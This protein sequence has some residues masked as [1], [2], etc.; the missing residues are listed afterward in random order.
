[1]IYSGYNWLSHQKNKTKNIHNDET[2]ILNYI[3]GDSIS[4]NLSNEPFVNTL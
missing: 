4:H 2:V 1:M 3:G